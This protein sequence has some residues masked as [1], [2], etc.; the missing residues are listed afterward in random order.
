M[1]KD[2]TYKRTSDYKHIVKRDKEFLGCHDVPMLHTAVLMS[3]KHK[4]SDRLT[5]DPDK[6]E[7]YDGPVD[8]TVALSISTMNTGRLK[9]SSIV[10]FLII[11]HLQYYLIDSL[12]LGQ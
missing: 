7:S 1:S 5:Y 6:V 12:F 10:Q 8:D 2:Y 3:L 11:L 4:A 9:K